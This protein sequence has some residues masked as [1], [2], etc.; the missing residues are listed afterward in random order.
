MNAFVANSTLYVKK[1]LERKGTEVRYD[2]L[3]SEQK[4]LFDEAKARE[5]SEVIQSMALRRI[6]EEEEKLVE[7][8]KDRHIPMRWVLT[9]KPLHPP[10]PPK[11]PGPHVATASGKW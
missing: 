2:Q 3:N 5:V 8:H 6:T 11:G 7:R 10:E 4:S 9:W 1:V